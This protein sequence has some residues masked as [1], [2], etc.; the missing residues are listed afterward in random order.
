MA[1][2]GYLMTVLR[3]IHLNPV[4]AGKCRHP[5]EYAY[6]SYSDYFAN[7]MIDSRPVLERMPAWTWGM[8]APQG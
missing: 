7:E 2:G 6:S 1:D 8:P 4:K 5:G 3:F